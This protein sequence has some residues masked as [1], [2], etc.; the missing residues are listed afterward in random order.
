MERLDTPDGD[1]LDIHHLEGPADA[2]LLILLHGLEGSVRSHYIQGLFT[3]AR[4]RGWHAAAMI[5]RSCGSELNRARRFYHS[6]ETTDIAFLVS[7]L[8]T[9]FA[10]SPLLLAGV[11]L[12]GNVLL[13]YLGEQ[14]GNVS[15]R[16]KAA[17][18]V[19]VPFDLARS[20]QHI[21]R[22]FSKVYQQ[23]FLRSL[24]AKARLKL[25]QF[26]ELAS[27][28]SL[29]KASTM[30]EFDDWFTAPVHG[31]RDAMDYYG[32]SSSIKWIER[33]STRTLLLSAVDDPFLPPQVL[34]EVRRI[35]SRNPNLEL[36]FPPHGG[37][38]GF[39]SGR[40]PF[41]PV[42]YLEQRVGDFLSRQLEV[43]VTP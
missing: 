15:P 2:P 4:Q 32:Q 12:G 14:A 19:S 18:A 31:F 41:N 24:N 26:P 39:I 16:I 25:D 9:R 21:D 37:H 43:S 13:K 11:S 23:S 29:Q 6:G 20:S 7:H 38:V 30:F 17:A 5:F 28:D 33:I 40:N 3:E 35:A 42:Y 34:D 27:R 10:G 22:G 1:F 36:E 8:E